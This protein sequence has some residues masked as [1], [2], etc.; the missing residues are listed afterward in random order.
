ME[1]QPAIKSYFFE[2][3]YKD[4]RNTIREGWQTNLSEARDNFNQF[5]TTLPGAFHFGVGVSIIV[6]GSIVFGLTSLVHI[7]LL[8]AVAG[9]IYFAFSVIWG[10]DKLYRAVN[11]IF[12]ACPHAGCYHNFDIPVYHCPNCG[13]GHTRLHPGPYGILKRTCQC[14][15]KLP[16]T[17]LNGR[18]KLYA[19]CPK[20][21]QP[22]D[23][24]ESRPIVIPVIGAPSVG[25]T[26]FVTSLVH[27]LKED[28]APRDEMLFEFTDEVSK[29]SY[30]RNLATFE[31]G[32]TPLKTVEAQPTAINIFLQPKNQTLRRILYLY[33]PAGEAYLDTT[34][35]QV[36]RFYNYFHGA[37]FLIDP[38][39]IPDFHHEY[40]DQIDTNSVRPS[41]E[42]LEDVYDRIIINLEKNFG[43][44]PHQK[45][46]APF[47]VLLTKVDVAD[48]EDKFGESAG[49]RIQESDP[50]KFKTLGEA[51]HE[52]CREFLEEYG[53]GYML[54]RFDAKFKNYRFFAVSSAGSNSQGVEEPLRWLFQHIDRKLK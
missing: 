27:Q 42:P 50:E 30:E 43:I 32:S 15:A 31:V 44:K 4:L 45:V 8:L 2:K 21:E 10:A 37:F 26:C 41:T 46:K 35:T 33:D 28:I 17:F 1:K 54:D 13:V 6:F 36:H 19:T 49:Q 39:S 9:V 25:K 34:N 51:Q 29:L 7:L 40:A 12:V 47:A 24:K 48:L 53:M 38:F 14:G 16:Q 3:G 23:A 18:K 52:A 22:I 11:K 5:E 20:C